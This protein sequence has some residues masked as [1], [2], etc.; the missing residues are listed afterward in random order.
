MNFVTLRKRVPKIWEENEELGLDK[1][2]CICHSENSHSQVLASFILNERTWMSQCQRD[3]EHIQHSIIKFPESSLAEWSDS[4][5]T[6]KP[7][8]SHFLPWLV[9]IYKQLSLW[10]RL[11][12]DAVVK[13]WP[14]KRLSGNQVF[15]E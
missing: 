3:C 13:L 11:W 9:N 2:S 1:Q 15:I 5:S 10:K 8:H 12:L 14:H 4:F 7:L 6:V